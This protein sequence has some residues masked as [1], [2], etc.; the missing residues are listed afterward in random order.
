MTFVGLRGL[1]GDAFSC[2]NGRL[3]R[4]PDVTLMQRRVDLSALAADA[5]EIRMQT[6]AQD[7]VDLPVVERRVQA[8]RQTF[9]AAAGHSRG[10]SG[11]LPQPLLDALRREPDGAGKF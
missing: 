1:R 3:N 9:G 11:N 6:V 7:L 8:A 10:L 5:L 2:R 4:I